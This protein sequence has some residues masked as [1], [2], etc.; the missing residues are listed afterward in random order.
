MLRKVR[1]KSPFAMF[2]VAH[3]YL[4]HMRYGRS[5]RFNRRSVNSCSKNSAVLFVT[6]TVIIR[7]GNFGT[8]LDLSAQS[9]FP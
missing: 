9:L 2:I 6:G 8:G 4:L 3:V 1:Q 7:H 5:A